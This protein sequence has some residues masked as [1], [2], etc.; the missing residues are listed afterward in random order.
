MGGRALGPVAGTL[1][2]TQP[3]LF[4]QCSRQVLDWDTS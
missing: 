2:V 3:G 4:G 1:T